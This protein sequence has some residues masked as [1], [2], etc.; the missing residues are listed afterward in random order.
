MARVDLDTVDLLNAAG[1]DIGRLFR[2][3]VEDV[4][5]VG[6]AINAS[7]PIPAKAPEFAEF[8]YL[9][10]LLESMREQRMMD[11]GVD[12]RQVDIA[13]SVPFT[14]VDAQA[15]V[16]IQKSGYGVRSLGDKGEKKGYVL[17]QTKYAKGVRVLPEAANSHDMLE[18]SRLLNIKP[19]QSF[20]EIDVVVGN[21]IRPHSK[22]EPRN[23]L[24]MSTRSLL[25]AMYFLSHGISVPPEHV[26]AGLVKLTQYPDGTPFDWSELTGDLLRV[27][28]SKHRPKQAAAAVRYRNYWFYIEDT[29]VESKTTISLFRELTRL[30][31]VGA[32]EGQLPVLTLPVGK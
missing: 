21:Q 12:T 16:S 19:G 27:C 31:K 11:L 2:I 1:W 18:V 10:S 13:T 30:Q 6:N 14:D 15:L 8:R 4:N 20:Y 25:E 24:T 3:L 7:G 28:V 32:A 23:R 29:D 5:G 26:Q 9:T 17:T 22:S